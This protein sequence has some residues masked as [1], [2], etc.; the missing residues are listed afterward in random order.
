MGDSIGTIDSATGSTTVKTI[1][2]KLLIVIESSASD[3]SL[4]GGH[5]TFHK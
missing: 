2:V 1:T 4:N 3:P 5:E